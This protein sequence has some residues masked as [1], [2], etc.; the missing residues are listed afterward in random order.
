MCYIK[1]IVGSYGSVVNTVVCTQL[2]I[3]IYLHSVVNVY[4]E[5]VKL[6]LNLRE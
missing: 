1:H 2:H 5:V 4:M 6:G 3:L